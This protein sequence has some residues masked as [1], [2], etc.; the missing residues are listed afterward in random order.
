M[1]KY[2]PTS[3]GRRGMTKATADLSK[4]KPA[5][6]LL[7]HLKKRAGRNSKG[8][9]TTRHKGGGHKKQYRIVDFKQKKFDVWGRVE[10]IEYDPYR[11]AHIAKV[12]YEDGE[13]RYILASDEL[14]KGSKIITSE[15]AEFKEGNRTKLERIP[16]GTF[17][18]N[19]ELTPKK[20]GQLA[21]SAGSAVQVL[22]NE[23]KYAQLKIPSGEVRKVLK[24]GY[25]TIGK[26]SNSEH[27]LEVLGKAGRSRWRGIRPTV[28]GSAMNAV[29]HPYGGGEGRAQRGTKRPKTK[30]GKVTGGRKT[31]KKKKWSNTLII[32]RRKTK[33]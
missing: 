24:S 30:W 19:V 6:A 7:K 16:V 25:A 1:K 31:R 23:G 9:I 15:K 8:R 33:R 13:R 29:D 20:G 5:K 14:R 11:S 4:E 22:G 26:V 27:N 28:R 12:I 32:K 21:R 2:K 18:H 10:G 17:V 3:P